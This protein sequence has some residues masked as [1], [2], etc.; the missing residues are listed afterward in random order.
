MTPQLAGV[1]DVIPAQ[2]Q[3]GCKSFFVSDSAAVTHMAQEAVEWVANEV[4]FAHCKVGPS[5]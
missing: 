4:P 1:C 3:S 2:Y 5:A